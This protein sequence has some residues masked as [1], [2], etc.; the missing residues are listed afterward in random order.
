MVELRSDI[1]VSVVELF[2]DLV[3]TDFNIS[4]DES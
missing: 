2:F 1:L 4:F 3:F